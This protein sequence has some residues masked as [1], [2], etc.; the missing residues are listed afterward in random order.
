MSKS[1]LCLLT[2]NSTGVGQ[3]GKETTE[4]KTGY[5]RKNPGEL[6]SQLTRAEILL[7]KA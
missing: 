3:Q 2:P 5:L 7:G 1:W 6:A 4:L